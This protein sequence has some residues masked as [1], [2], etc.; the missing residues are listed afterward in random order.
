MLR[1]KLIGTTVKISTEGFN[2]VEVSVDAGLGIVAAPQL[3]KHDPDVDG[4][5]RDPP[6]RHKLN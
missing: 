6:L 2:G 4:S 3:L 5:E 1:A